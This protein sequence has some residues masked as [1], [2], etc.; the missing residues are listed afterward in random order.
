M[1]VRLDLPV[2]ILSFAYFHIVNDVCK[3]CSVV[4]AWL[5]IIIMQFLHVGMID[6]C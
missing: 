2:I 3:K 1:D 5:K 6:P 4:V